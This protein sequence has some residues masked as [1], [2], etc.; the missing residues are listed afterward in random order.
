MCD[1]MF[2]LLVD[3]TI[4]W[5]WNFNWDGLWK[6]RPVYVI[7]RD[8]KTLD[9]MPGSSTTEDQEA[10]WV[11]PDDENGLDVAT[12]FVPSHITTLCLQCL[13]SC[14]VEIRGVLPDIEF[15]SEYSVSR[16]ECVCPPPPPPP[17]P[18]NR[19]DT[20]RHVGGIEGIVCRIKRN[21]QVTW[22]PL[23][24]CGLINIELTDY[25]GLTE[26]KKILVIKDSSIGSLEK[27]GRLDAGV[28]A[29]L[30]PFLKHNNLY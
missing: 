15:P 22:L 25:N 30:I 16:T 27:I 24:D 4:L 17:R 1:F 7:Q 11:E 20:V 29:S 9:V 18:E 5:M 23:S 21:G 13:D 26:S 6:E 14:N 10:I 3:S 2:P 19:F 12:G 8:E 28:I